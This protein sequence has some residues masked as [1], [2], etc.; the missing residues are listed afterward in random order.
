SP[1]HQ[2]LEPLLVVDQ[3]EE[4]FQLDRKRR[5]IVIN[6]LAELANPRERTARDEST[7]E[8][9]GGPRPRLLLSLREDYLAHLEDLKTKIPGIMRSRYRLRPMSGL[10]AKDAIIKP[11]PPGLVSTR[12]AQTIIEIVTGQAQAGTQKPLDELEIEPALL[13]MFCHEL[14]RLRAQQDLQEITEKL[15][16]SSRD[17][18]V[19]GFYDGCFLGLRRAAKLREFVEEELVIEP[20]KRTTRPVTTAEQYD[21]T[22]ADVRK[23]EERRLVRIES[24]FNAHHVELIHDLVVEAAFAGRAAR[25]KQRDKAVRD[26]RRIVWLSLLAIAVFGAGYGFQLWGARKEQRKQREEFRDILVTQG[27]EALLRDEIPTAVQLLDLAGGQGLPRNRAANIALGR[28]LT[29]LGGVRQ[30]VQH[31]PGVACLRLRSDAGRLLTCGGDGTARIWPLAERSGKPDKQAIVLPVP[32]FGD[33]AQPGPPQ[34]VPSHAASWVFAIAAD[35]NATVVDEHSAQPALP[36]LREPVGAGGR[37]GTGWV[38]CISP[39]DGG[40]AIWSPRQKDS[41]RRWRKDPGETSLLRTESAPE[42]A[43]ATCLDAGGVLAVTGSGDVVRFTPGKEGM[44]T[45]FSRS[46]HGPAEHVAGAPDG[47]LVV[48]TTAGSPR[49]RLWRAGD[50]ET[51]EGF[52]GLAYME[53]LA[54]VG[55][56]LLAMAPARPPSAGFSPGSA[57]A[58][59]RWIAPPAAAPVGDRSTLVTVWDLSSHQLV[60]SVERLGADAI[61]SPGGEALAIRSSHQIELWDTAAWRP[62]STRAL[63]GRSRP[64]FDISRDR[65]GALAIAVAEGA[66]ARV[67]EPVSLGGTERRA[68]RAPERFGAWPVA[69]PTLFIAPWVAPRPGEFSTTWPAVA[70]KLFSSP[71]VATR[72]TPIVFSADGP[73]AAATSAPGKGIDTALNLDTGEVAAVEPSDAPGRETLGVWLSDRSVVVALGGRICRKPLAVAGATRAVS[74]AGSATTPDAS[75]IV[76]HP[77]DPAV[78]VVRESAAEWISFAA[79]KPS[80][81]PFALP[82]GPR[83]VATCI[84]GERDQVVVAR[85]DGSIVRVDG[86]GEARMLPFA[87]PAITA[88]RGSRTG[89]LVVAHAG[90]VDLIDPD[91][92][93][94]HIDTPATDAALGEQVARLLWACG[95][96]G[97]TAWDPDRR[98]MVATLRAAMTEPRLSGNARF[99][100]TGSEL[101]R[102]PAPPR[103]DDAVLRGAPIVAGALSDDGKVIA[104][105]DARENELV[106]SGVTTRLPP[107]AG[108][109]AGPGFAAGKLVVPSGNIVKLGPHALGLKNAWAASGPIAALAWN[110]PRDRFVA[111]DSEL[112]IAVVDAT[113]G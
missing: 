69:A 63:D 72:N 78:L 57:L 90:G 70:P 60:F 37:A 40:F 87:L 55:D 88:L 86:D 92:T 6:E 110:R 56:R 67:I 47:N 96:D 3:F 51:V 85:D 80:A 111:V 64:R 4:L 22:E 97:C 11:A 26:R 8:F 79:A 32:A 50:P 21:V 39:D 30:S 61:L 109:L 62:L 41:L 48:A 68:G 84:T 104:Q 91:D 34:L 65:E 14:D 33:G 2:L 27:R 16:E 108:A 9:G 73:W 25:N 7:G 81:T 77:K 31:I 29:L 35:G 113:T 49:L 95:R 19:K 38:G 102:L 112:A 15:T 74:C 71:L 103:A 10:Q 106:A 105:N 44:R 23:L 100:G 12:V 24:R 1:R 54:V 45:L 52:V 36:V 42:L 28:A 75:I 46:L 82:A 99:V 93:R 83:A 58:T 66:I 89:A 43:E 76:A 94:H 107:A 13:S 5:E 59:D 98:I 17:P 18:I 20:G 101:L 53:R